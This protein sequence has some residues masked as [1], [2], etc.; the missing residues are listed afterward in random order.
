MGVTPESKLDVFIEGELINLCVPTRGY[1]LTSDWYSWFN[2]KTT[3]KYLFQGVFPNTQEDQL[4]FFETLKDRKRLCLII[5]RKSNSEYVGVVSLSNLNYQTRSA[6][7]AIVITSKKGRGR[8]M[9]L[10]SLEAIA[11]VSEWGFLE[12]GLHRILAGLHRDHEG[13]QN[14]MEIFGFRLEGILRKEFVKGAMVGDVIKIACIKEDYL[15]ICENRGRYWPGSD[16]VMR[17]IKS[18]PEA[19]FAS[20]LE[21]F[22]KTEGEAYYDQIFR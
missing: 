8:E 7:L 20:R 17:R 2:D 10:V 6:E 22:L 18:L 1:A 14:R 19:T 16:E 12:I 4:Q 13:L 11:R 5:Q 9:P 21:Q 3:V 15:R